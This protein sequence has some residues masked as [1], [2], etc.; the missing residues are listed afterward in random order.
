MNT[1]GARALALWA[2][3]HA[4]VPS[5]AVAEDPAVEETPL[6]PP[7]VYEEAAPTADEVRLPDPASYEVVYVPAPTPSPQPMFTLS[8]REYRIDR[9][10]R[11]ARMF[12]WLQVATGAF[13]LAMLAPALVREGRGE[14]GCGWWSATGMGLLAFSAAGLGSAFAT[15]NAAS[16]LAYEGVPIRRGV[17]RFAIAL[18]FVPYAN[19]GAFVMTSIAYGRVRRAR[20]LLPNA[21]RRHAPPSVQPP[22]LGPLPDVPPAAPEPTTPWRRHGL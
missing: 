4:L 3:V 21:P 20:A 13:S 8:E 7:L 18:S 2:L 12:G 22:R 11:R 6:P 19:L 5:A 15:N 17:G 14:C 16:R 9:A 10:M 1:H